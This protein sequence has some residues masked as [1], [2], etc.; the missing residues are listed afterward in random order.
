[1][2]P[3]LAAKINEIMGENSSSFMTWTDPRQNNKYDLD[4]NY[5]NDNITEFSA[6]HVA[7]HKWVSNNKDTP[8]LHLDIHGKGKR[9]G[10]Q[11]NQI[12]LGNNSAIYYFDNTS[13]ETNLIG[14]MYQYLSENISAIYV[15]DS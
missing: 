3:K 10:D 1:M 2:V 6:F 9:T 7:L 4:P 13:D 12:D 5:L 15:G 8:L 14:P 11:L